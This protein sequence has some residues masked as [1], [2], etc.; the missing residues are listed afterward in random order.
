MEAVFLDMS[1]I[2][3]VICWNV[4]SMPIEGAKGEAEPH[5]F[6]GFDGPFFAMNALFPGLD[7]VSAEHTR[8]AKVV[9]VGR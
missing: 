5:F 6:G 4:D 8:A 3:V 7:V 1:A 2:V 9:P